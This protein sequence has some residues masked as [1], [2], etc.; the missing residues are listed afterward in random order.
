M[1][2]TKSLVEITASGPSGTRT[3]PAAAATV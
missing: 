3:P 1:G 2:T